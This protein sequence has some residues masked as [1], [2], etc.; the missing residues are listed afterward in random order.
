MQ[1]LNKKFWPKEIIHKEKSN[2]I[3]VLQ[4]NNNEN[5][6]LE[7]INKIYK[8]KTEKIYSEINIEE[9]PSKISFKEFQFLLEKIKI[10]TPVKIIKGNAAKTRKKLILYD[11]ETIKE[12]GLSFRYLNFLNVENIINIKE[13]NF[14]Y[15][16]KYKYEEI[17][18]IGTDPFFERAISTNFENSIIY[19]FADQNS[20]LNELQT[21]ENVNI[22]LFDKER[23][24]RG[25]LLNI[26]NRKSIIIKKKAH[27]QKRNLEEF[28]KLYLNKTIL[29]KHFYYY[30]ISS[31]SKLKFPSLISLSINKDLF[32]SDKTL[33]TI[34]LKIIIE[35][36]FELI[37]IPSLIKLD[38]VI[39]D[40]ILDQENLNI[41]QTILQIINKD[42][43][44]RNKVLKNK[45]IIITT[46]E[47]IYSGKIARDKIKSELS[48][49][50]NYE[51]ND[52][53]FINLLIENRENLNCKVLHK[54]FL[55]SINKNYINKSYG[56]YYFLI[57]FNFNY[58]LIDCSNN[59][60]SLDYY[61]DIFNTI[62]SQDDSC[63]YLKYLENKKYL[64]QIRKVISYTE[65]YFLEKIR[66]DINFIFFK[67]LTETKIDSYNL[68]S[69]NF[70]SCFWTCIFIFL[71]YERK[72][73]ENIDCIKNSHLIQ[74]NIFK[75]RF[76]DFVNQLSINDKSS[77][78][79][80]LMFFIMN[81]NTLKRS[82]ERVVITYFPDFYD[83]S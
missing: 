63:G 15:L 49:N 5:E 35:K 20:I 33:I 68:N 83:L 62:L 34:F 67:V 79:K 39:L 50:F 82:Q 44:Q 52:Q 72:I 43:T 24:L 3:S 1:S 48:Q 71:K 54:K 17:I 51:K 38:L 21:K 8:S 18:L 42:F 10:I 14:E 25:N 22:I 58:L 4:W 74:S 32:Q 69:E 75:K 13:I 80:I 57:R 9:L 16:E 46:I 78:T 28:E 47:L 30:T 12:Y 73:P 76:I 40:Y 56:F 27:I 66:N 59:I 11:G 70:E 65:K 41:F 31:H 61:R 7:F 26:L 60:Y 53:I 2:Q 81:R 36:W 23:S 77:P 45:I 6:I 37:H 55:K 29:K 64:S 19:K